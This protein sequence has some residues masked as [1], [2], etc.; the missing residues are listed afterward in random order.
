MAKK[1]WDQRAGEMVGKNIVPAA[2]ATIGD[3]V[4]LSIGF[5]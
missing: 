4:K 3:W 1:P 5:S 2:K